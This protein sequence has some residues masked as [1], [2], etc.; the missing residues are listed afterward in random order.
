MENDDSK[1]EWLKIQTR[2]AA[3]LVFSISILA[4]ICCVSLRPPI[5]DWR[6]YLAFFVGA[7]CGIVTDKRIM[8]KTI[9]LPN[10]LIYVPLNRRK[11]FK[12][13]VSQSVTYLMPF[14]KQFPRVYYLI[15]NIPFLIILAVLVSF[16]RQ[17][18][19]AFKHAAWAFFFGFVSNVGLSD[20]AFFAYVLLTW[21]KKNT[22]IRS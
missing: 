17:D 14:W 18:V 13:S 22:I 11:P 3:I 1:L 7:A 6:Y 8:T 16:T 4:F 9:G 12:M 5:R 20:G 15:A 19:F 2:N 21:K 10:P